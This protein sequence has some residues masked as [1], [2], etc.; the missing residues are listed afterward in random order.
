LHA[1]TRR[2]LRRCGHARPG[3]EAAYPT[4]LDDLPPP[5]LLVYPR[6]TVVAEKLEAI[7]SFGMANSRMKDYFDY[8]H[9]RRK[10]RSIRKRWLRPSPRPSRDAA[11][12]CRPN[13]H[14]A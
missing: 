13:C 12:R 6:E 3:E 4:L 14:L 8:A 2:R 9:S 5:R 10:A 7:V 11:R 1:A